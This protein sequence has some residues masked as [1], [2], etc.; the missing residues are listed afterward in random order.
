VLW[1]FC[2]FYQ[3]LARFLQLPALI[4][5]SIFREKLSM[6]MERTSQTEAI[7]LPFPSIPDHQVAVPF[8]QKQKPS[9]SVMAFS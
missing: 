6:Q 2:A 7:R 1:C 4:V 9:M 3:H 5:R 8:G